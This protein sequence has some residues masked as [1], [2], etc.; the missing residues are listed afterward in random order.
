MSDISSVSGIK[1][2]IIKHDITAHDVANVNTPGFEEL[3]AHQVE[4]KSDG[5]KISHIT[6]TKNTN[7]EISNTDLANESKEQIQNKNSLAA[8]VRALKVKDEMLGDIIDIV[9]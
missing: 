3:T 9:G 6:K 4:N 2:A 5:T 8:N 1:A 7:K